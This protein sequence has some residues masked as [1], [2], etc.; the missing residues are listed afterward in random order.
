[1]REIEGAFA[2]AERFELFTGDRSKRNLH[3]YRKLGYSVFKRQELTERVTLVFME[4]H[5]ES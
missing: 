5:R 2:Q 3:L 4:K 1:M